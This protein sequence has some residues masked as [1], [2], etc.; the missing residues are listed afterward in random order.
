[1]FGRN[2]WKGLF[3]WMKATLGENDFIGPGDLELVTVMDD[4]QAAI[5]LILDYQRRVGPP[6]SVPK[7]FA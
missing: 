7:A 4:V 1:M 3:K 2:Y 6:E 5:D